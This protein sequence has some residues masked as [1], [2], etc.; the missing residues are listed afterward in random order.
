MMRGALLSSSIPLFK[1]KKKNLSLQI[2]SK[3]NPFFK[4]LPV[5]PPN[6]YFKNPFFLGAKARN[7]S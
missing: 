1:E 3:K 7:E 6:F 4:I 2:Q 5:S